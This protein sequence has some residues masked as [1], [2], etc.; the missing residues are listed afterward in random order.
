MCLII[1]LYITGTWPTM[2]YRGCVTMVRVKYTETVYHG[3][4][5][6]DSSAANLS[7][8]FKIC[9]SMSCCSFH[10]STLIRSCIVY[11]EKVPSYR[12]NV[13]ENFYYVVI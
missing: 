12:S 7:G 2:A 5:L 9:H 11:S 6:L 10:Y 13:T 1:N 8:C 3:E 4:A